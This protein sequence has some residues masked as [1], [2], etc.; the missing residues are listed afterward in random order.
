VQ[1]D[2]IPDWPTIASL[3][4]NAFFYS[5]DYHLHFRHILH[6]WIV[7]RHTWPAIHGPLCRLCQNTDERTFHMEHMR[8]HQ[9]DLC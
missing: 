6:R 7:T 2:Y 1:G 4:S 9:R 5:K 8:G 3:Y